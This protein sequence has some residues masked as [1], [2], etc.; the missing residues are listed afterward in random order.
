MVERL[1]IGERYYFKPKIEKEIIDSY[2]RMNCGI[3]MNMCKIALVKYFT[4]RNL[5]YHRMV[6][7]YRYSIEFNTNTKEFDGIRS[8]ING[9]N[10]DCRDFELYDKAQSLEDEYNKV[11]IKGDINESNN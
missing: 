8:N 1:I 10:W 6:D 2:T 3:D 7:R 11:M 5:T 4:I 9:Y